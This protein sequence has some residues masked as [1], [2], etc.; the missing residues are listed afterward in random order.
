MLFTPFK[1]M[2]E[3]LQLMA[4]PVVTLGTVMG[5]DI[6]PLQNVYA[7]KDAPSFE[8]VGKY[9]VGEDSAAEIIASDGKIPL[10]L[11]LWMLVENP[12][13]LQSVVDMPLLQS[14]QVNPILTL[15]DKS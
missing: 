5:A 14:I 12:R 13:V 7:D 10:V 8:Q 4:L 2:L 11:L 15:R 6:S 3:L 9:G 1:D